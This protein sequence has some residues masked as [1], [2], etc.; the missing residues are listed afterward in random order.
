MEFFRQ[1]S[2]IFKIL[3]PYWNCKEVGI[4]LLHSTFLVLRTWLS[5]VVARIDGRIVRDLV[6]AD[7][8]GFLIGLAWWFLIAIP[9]TYTNSMIRFLQSKLG[10]AFRT[11]LTRYAHDLYLDP[12]KAYYKAMCLDGRI[13][14]IDQ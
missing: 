13:E 2:A 10:I 6:R 14:N 1:L 9:A 5:V 3:I 7:R 4:L 11:R 8:R 12:E